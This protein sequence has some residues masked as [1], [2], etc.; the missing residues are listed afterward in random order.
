LHVDKTNSNNKEE[1][2]LFAFSEIYPY[3]K[4]KL[5]TNAT[6]QGTNKD[7]EADKNLAYTFCC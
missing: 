4:G 2:F 5:D 7:Y 1:D 3:E 6:K